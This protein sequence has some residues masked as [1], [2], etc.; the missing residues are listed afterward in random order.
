[1]TRKE[2][3]TVILF[4]VLENTKR[5]LKDE[6]SYKVNGKKEIGIMPH[7]LCTINPNSSG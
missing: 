1:M 4:D 6:L 7:G 5:K 3:I 2:E